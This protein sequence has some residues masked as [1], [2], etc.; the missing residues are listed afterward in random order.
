MQ[1]TRS[2]LMCRPDFFDVTYD[3]NPWMTDN[4]KRTS[5]KRA[6]RQWHR[7]TQEISARAQVELVEPAPGLPD[8]PFVANAGFVFEDVAVPSR[9]LC[10]E[11]RGEEPHF[12]RWFAAHGFSIE[13]MPDD[14]AFEGAG[15]ALVDRGSQRVWA[16]WGHRSARES[17]DALSQ[18]LGVDVIS[19]RL[20]D[21]RFY[22]L[23][24]CFCPL[25]GGHVMYYPPAFDEESRATIARLVPAALRVSIEEADALHFACNAVN[26]GA[27]VILNRAS[28]ALKQQLAALGYDTVEVD[29]SEFLKAGGAAKCLTLRLDEPR[30]PAVATAR[31]TA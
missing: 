22:H 2:I 30:V 31:Q 4:F 29:V 12:E 11:R 20:A 9:F 1:A 6:A 19:L 16:G 8:M 14:I 17:H 5:A 3:I 24:T 10:V 27:A 23:D 25:E 18:L 15:D 26:I 21:P 7:L 28:T 13:R